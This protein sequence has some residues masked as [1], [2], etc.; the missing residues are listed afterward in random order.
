MTIEVANESG[1][2]VDE[3]AIERAARHALDTMGISPEAEL[4]I[5]VVDVV[6]MTELH[7]QHM[8]L[9]GPTDVL[10]FPMDDAWA[11]PDGAPVMVGDVVLCPEV[12]AEQAVAAGHSTDAELAMLTTHGVLHLLGYDHEEP[13]EHAEMFAL[14][15]Q[16][17]ASLKA[18]Q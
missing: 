4:S 12:A 7:V 14:Q 2:E 8:D 16:L 6:R 13:E 3:A 5:L 10:A 11:E 9:P 17:L 18:G 1:V 15:A